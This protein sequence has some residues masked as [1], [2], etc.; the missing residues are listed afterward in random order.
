MSL[1]FTSA[2]LVLLQC[3]FITRAYRK[4][5]A[6]FYNILM[7]LECAGLAWWS[8]ELSESLQIS[9]LSSVRQ[10]PVMN[11]AQKAH[12]IYYR[13]LSPVPGPEISL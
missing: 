4:S 12:I 11:T 9:A 13:G 8:W 10:S 2:R 1:G 5:T 7:E 6:I 3:T